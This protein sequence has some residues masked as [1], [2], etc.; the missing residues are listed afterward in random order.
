[1]SE[2]LK[3]A[4][5]AVIAQVMIDRGFELIE[6]TCKQHRDDFFIEVLAD[7]R[8][9]GI[10]VDECS[11]LNKAIRHYIE[12]E[13]VLAEE[14]YRL[15]VC[16]PGLDRPLKVA[17]DFQRVK[18]QMVKFHLAEAQKGK[19]EHDG[20]IEEVMADRIKIKTVAGSFEIPLNKIKKAVQIIEA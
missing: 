9:G 20:S 5:H 13:A 16:S 18:G 4:L 17:K 15:T 3:E 7:R 11:S 1:M 14:V 2:A 19:V 8:Q 12:A 10:T 6:V